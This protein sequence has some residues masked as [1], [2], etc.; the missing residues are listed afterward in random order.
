[1]KNLLKEN[2]N[3]E[4]DCTQFIK[5]RV[6]IFYKPKL[7]PNDLSKIRGNAIQ[8]IIEYMK[9]SKVY[10]RKPKLNKRDLSPDR[11][12]KDTRKR[13]RKETETEKRPK[14]AKTHLTSIL[15]F[16]KIN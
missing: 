11:N 9:K 5:L 6:S 1:M 16:R 4:L 8:K 14:K 7:T 12:I 15:D 13:H 3:W 2:S 10:E